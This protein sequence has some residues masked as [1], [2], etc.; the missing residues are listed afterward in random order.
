MRINESRC[1]CFNVRIFGLRFM[2]VSRY[3]IWVLIRSI[4]YAEIAFEKQI[5]KYA[6][7]EIPTEIERSELGVVIGTPDHSRRWT[8]R[9]IRMTP[10]HEVHISNFVFINR[11]L[12]EFFLLCQEIIL[13]DRNYRYFLADFVLSIVESCA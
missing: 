5:R 7:F 2:V 6:D 12:H 10:C 1:L 9:A 4:K 8:T 11:K 13:M 3:S